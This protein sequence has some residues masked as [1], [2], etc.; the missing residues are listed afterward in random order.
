M[1][2]IVIVQPGTLRPKDKEKLTKAGHTV[3]E[4]PDS[5]KVVF[6]NMDQSEFAYTNCATCGE[7][8]YLNVERM[9]VLKKNERAFYCSSGHGQSFTK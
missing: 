1:K 3:I 6:R 2:Q 4:H 5:S 8:I 7:R 9:E